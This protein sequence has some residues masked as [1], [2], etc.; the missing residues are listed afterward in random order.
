MPTG[1]NHA[2]AVANGKV[3]LE[4]ALRWRRTEM[5]SARGLSMSCR[6]ELGETSLA[7]LVHRT[8]QDS[9]VLDVIDAVQKVM[10]HAS[11]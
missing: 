6:V 3:A 11:A 7:F 10:A 4:L 1:S 2:V 5:Q 8:V 9:D